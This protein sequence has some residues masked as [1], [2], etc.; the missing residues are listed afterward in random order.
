ME[1]FPRV[2][3]SSFL[4]RFGC[5]LCFEVENEYRRRER[6][7]HSSSLMYALRRDDILPAAGN[8]RQDG[9]NQYRDGPTAGVPGCSRRVACS[10]DPF[11]GRD[12]PSSFSFLFSLVVLKAPKVRIRNI[13][14]Y[15]RYHTMILYLLDNSFQY[16]YVVQ[17]E[18]KKKKTLSSG[19]KRSGR[20][21][22]FSFF[23]FFSSS[24]LAQ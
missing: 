17:P 22:F 10:I 14:P 20:G 19:K 24:Y 7:N 1:K 8:G 3:P 15:Y 6:K 5:K 16:T 4:R 12:L 23:V 21:S 2:F 11:V 9:R 18:K 13:M